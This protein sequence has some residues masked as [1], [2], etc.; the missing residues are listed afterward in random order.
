MLVIK[1]FSETLMV[2]VGRKASDDRR[3]ISFLGHYGP[4]EALDLQIC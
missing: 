2:R 3:E 1:V 4:F